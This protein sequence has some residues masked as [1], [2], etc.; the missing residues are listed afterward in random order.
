MGVVAKQRVFLDNQLYQ[1]TTW[2]AGDTV[3]SAKLNNIEEGILNSNCTFVVNI[4]DGG[5]LDKTWQEIYN[6]NYYFIVDQI[7]WE[8]SAG[9]TDEN[10]K[11][12]FIIS[13][14]Y[15]NDSD[16]E[17]LAITVDSSSGI[18]SRLFKTDNRNSYPQIVGMEE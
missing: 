2:A 5:Y 8:G 7:R 12:I 18:H 13:D 1:P 17:I 9:M 11:C 4:N 10:R 16:Y 14:I 15:V 6:G 3:T